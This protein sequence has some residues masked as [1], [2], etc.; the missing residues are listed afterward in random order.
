MKCSYFMGVDANPRFEVCEVELAK[1][2]S[3]QVA[4]KNMACG[5]CGTDVH[6]YKGEEGSASVNPP[7]VA[8]I[9]VDIADIF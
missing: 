4:V 7:L 6:I 9:D 5:V 1:L 3:R 8:F 2:G